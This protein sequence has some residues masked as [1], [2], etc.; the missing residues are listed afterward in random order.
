MPTKQN[1][2]C[3]SFDLCYWFLLRVHVLPVPTPPAFCKTA[4]SISKP[5]RAL[6]HGSHFMPHGTV[7]Q[8][9]VAMKDHKHYLHLSAIFLHEQ[10]QITVYSNWKQISKKPRGLESALSLFSASHRA[11]KAKATPWLSNISSCILYKQY[12]TI[13]PV[14]ISGA[15][16]CAQ[17]PS[18]WFSL[19]LTRLTL[20]PT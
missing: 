18:S 6:M 11:H 7:C 14:E 19:Y 2:A 9:G 4:T 20:E 17:Q 15:P 16:F 5:C 12:K 10:K 8:N 1:F 3:I 13:S